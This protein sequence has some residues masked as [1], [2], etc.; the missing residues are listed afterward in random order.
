MNNIIYDIKEKKF[1][2]V[3]YVEE[4]VAGFKVY[5]TSDKTKYGIGNRSEYEFVAANRVVEMLN[6]YMKK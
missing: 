3:L 6:A 2:L 4:N 1:K 5:V